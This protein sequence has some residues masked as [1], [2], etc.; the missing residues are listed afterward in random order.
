MTKILRA[1]QKSIDKGQT[2]TNKR[3]VPEANDFLTQFR[4]AMYYK[5]VAGMNGAVNGLHTKGA[6]RNALT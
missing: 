4:K 6:G 2:T 1:V 5:L 3:L